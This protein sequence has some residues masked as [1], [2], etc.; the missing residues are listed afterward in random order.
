MGAQGPQMGGGVWLQEGAPGK[1]QGHELAAVLWG[2]PRRPKR[3]PRVAGSSGGGRGGRPP[4]IRVRR[5]EAAEC[6]GAGAGWSG[7]QSGRPPTRLTSISSGGGGEVG[8]G[9][10]PRHRGLGGNWVPAPGSDDAEAGA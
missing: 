7:E 8:D 6:W 1:G 2:T 5:A 9:G 3:G 4:V 10:R